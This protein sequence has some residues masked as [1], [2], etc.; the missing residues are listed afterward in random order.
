MIACGTATTYQHLL[1][2][3]RRAESALVAFSG[4]VDSTL[5]AR[6]A[7]DALGQ[8]ALALTAVSASLAP[9]ELEE[10]R[11]LAAR[12]GIEPRLE[13]S[14]EVSRPEYRRN[15]AERC[16]HCKSELFEICRR[17]AEELRLAV[18]VDGTNV[19]DAGDHRP[20][21]RAAMICG[22]RSPFVELDCDKARI[23]ALSAQLGLP[24][25]AKPEMACLA[26]RF[27]TGTPITGAHLRRVA[28][29]EE[30][31]RDLGFSQYRVRF[32]G[33]LARIE[34]PAGEIGRIAEAALRRRLLEGVR[35][36]GFRFVAVDLAGYRRGSSNPLAMEPL[37][38][39]SR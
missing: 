4:G 6:A 5:L 20:G 3:F 10:T 39:R 16:F 14:A 21:R 31:V 7:Y 19:D 30:V 22:V 26:S 34:L 37:E 1:A 38:L 17:V 12:I 25:A 29:A 36:A 33:E 23:R 18:I 27:P 13:R 15:D 2:W 9:S 24:T 28:A 11:R 8:R 32:H 35:G